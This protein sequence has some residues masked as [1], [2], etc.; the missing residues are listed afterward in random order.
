MA[1][2][3]RFAMKPASVTS[4]C[5]HG[6]LARRSALPHSEGTRDVGEAEG[7]RNGRS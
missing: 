6:A 2:S 4:A 3:I 1:S 5:L 7:L